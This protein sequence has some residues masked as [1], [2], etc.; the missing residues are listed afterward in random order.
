MSERL[1][2]S[3]RSTVMLPHLFDVMLSTI[4]AGVVE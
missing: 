4:A 2:P 1:L 3:Q